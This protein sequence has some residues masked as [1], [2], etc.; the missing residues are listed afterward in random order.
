[1]KPEIFPL[2]E[3][4]GVDIAAL[5]RRIDRVIILSIL[6]AHGCVVKG[7]EWNCPPIGYSRCFQLLGFDILL[8]RY[9]QPRVLE[10]NYRPNLDY[11]RGKERRMKVEM[12]RDAILIGAPFAKA[13]AA[14][15]ARSAITSRASW[16]S[17]LEAHP[18]I[19][20]SGERR[21]AQ[22]LAGS[23]F[24][25]VWPPTHDDVA[26]SYRRVLEKVDRIPLEAIPGFKIPENVVLP[27][28][29]PKDP[30][31]DAKPQ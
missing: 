17:F 28:R 19:I 11:Y 24:V 12:I 13:Q 16:E 29:E 22:V 2:L 23:R 30:P 5:W 31:H 6:A 7:E 15:L 14:V 18:E 3:L 27:G 8:D 1:L 4:F 20:A 10:V 9:M 25:Q 26:K 21:R